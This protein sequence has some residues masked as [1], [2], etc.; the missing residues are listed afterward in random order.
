MKTNVLKRPIFVLAL[1]LVLIVGMLGVLDAG[2]LRPVYTTPE[3]ALTVWPGYLTPHS[4]YL[5]DSVEILRRQPFGRGEILFYRWQ[6]PGCTAD[7]SF[8]L[9][10][11][12]VER[13]FSL[14]GGWGWRAQGSFQHLPELDQGRCPIRADGFVAGSIGRS[15][16][17]ERFT[18]VSGYGGRGRAVRVAWE[19]GQVDESPL[20]ASGVFFF[21]RAGDHAVQRVELLDAAGRLLETTP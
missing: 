11:T 5:P 20:P 4:G 18:T 15:V 3:D 17:R 1:V 12:Y 14:R 7:G 16:G 2:W 6:T 9:A 10:A 19:D 13:A 21:S 8:H